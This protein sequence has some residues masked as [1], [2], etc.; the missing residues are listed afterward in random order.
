MVKSANI[1]VALRWVAQGWH[2]VKPDTITKCFGKAGILNNVLVVVG[3]DGADGLLHPFPEIDVDLEMQ[4][5]IEQTESGSSSC[6]VKEFVSRDGDL[7]V[8]FEMD[9]DNCETTFLGEL[10]DGKERQLS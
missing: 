5:L 10:T 2:K 3:L 4:H 8:C 9:D 6:S 7:S 1:L